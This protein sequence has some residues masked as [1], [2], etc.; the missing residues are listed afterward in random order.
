MWYMAPMRPVIQM[1]QPAIAYP[2]Q[3]QSHDCHHE[4]PFTIIDELIIHVLILKESAIQKPTK[5]HGPH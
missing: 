2:I 5:F 1:K 4:S 3:T